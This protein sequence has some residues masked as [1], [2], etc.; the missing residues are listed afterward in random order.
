M[1][2]VWPASGVLVSTAYDMARYLDANLSEAVAPARTPLVTA[3]QHARAPLFRVN[4][5]FTQAL[6]WRDFRAAPDVT[7]IDKTGGLAGTSTYIGFIPER[8]LGLVILANRG[9][10]DPTPLGHRLLLQLA[11]TTPVSVATP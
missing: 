3:M 9:K 1:P 8:H 11:R 10:Q 5:R 7:I 6:A 2:T 4:D